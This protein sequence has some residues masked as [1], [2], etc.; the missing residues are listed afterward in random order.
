M[1]MSDIESR[2][3]MAGKKT[4]LVSQTSGARTF[5]GREGITALD[6]DQKITILKDIIEGKLLVGQRCRKKTISRI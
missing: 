2:G 6:L 5:L 1:Q 4:D 3:T